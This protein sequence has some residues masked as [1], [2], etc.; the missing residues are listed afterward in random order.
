MNIYNFFG[1]KVPIILTYLSPIT[2]FNKIV[3][4]DIFYITAITFGPFI[5]FRAKNPAPKI[6]THETIHAYQYAETY[7][8]GFLLLYIYD[9]IRGLIKYKN[10]DIAYMKIRFEQ[11]AYGNES[12]QDYL[13]VRH[14][15]AW[16]DYDI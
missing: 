16:N 1:S 15:N 8:L 3:G 2:I 12:D 13:S 9:F 4:R 6:I 5:F 14:K 7:Y 11:E 10:P